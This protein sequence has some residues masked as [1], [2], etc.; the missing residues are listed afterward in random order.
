MFTTEP[1]ATGHDEPGHRERAAYGGSDGSGPAGLIDPALLVSAV[2][3]ARWLIV[4][5]GLLGAGIAAAYA[6]S[7]PKIY[8]STTQILLDPRDIKVIQN[9]ITPNGLPS[10]AT[11]A[12]VESQ[13]A[14][15]YSNEILSRAVAAEGLTTDPEYVGGSA[16]GMGAIIASINRA[17][18]G[19]A[20]TEAPD[21][22]RRE[23]RVIEA[24][25]RNLSVTRD[26]NSFI[27]NL[28]VKS[29]V[30]DRAARLSTTIARLFIDNL[31]VVQ[32][33]TARR[34]S[35]SLSS[36]LSELRSRV[37]SAERAV[38][39]YKAE[40]ALIGVGG[41]LVD[42]DYIIRMNDQLARAR[43][44]ITAL[45]VRAG[46]MQNASVEDVVQGTLPEELTSEAL[47]RLRTT[48]SQLAQESA[49]L[50]ARLGPRHP[51]RI[52][53]DEALSSAR[54][55]IEAELRRI[56]SA[57]QTELARA[58]LTEQQLSSQT[59]ELK[60]KQVTTSGSFVRLR[61]LEREVDASRAVYEAYLLR[62]RETG[63]Q[64]SI[65]TANVRIV[66]EAVPALDPVSLSR[67]VVIAAGG[68][69]GGVLAAA[70]AVVVA[71]GRIMFAPPASSGPR[72][73]FAADGRDAAPPEHHPRHADAPA[74]RDL[75]FAAPG[76][77]ASSAAFFQEV[78]RAEN[79]PAAA[80]ASVP[81]SDAAQPDEDDRAPVAEPAAEAR[82]ETEATGPVGEAPAPA[83]APQPAAAAR[84]EAE[85]QP[86]EAASLAPEFAEIRSEIEAVRHQLSLLRA[87]RARGRT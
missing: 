51:Q 60:A 2:W 45:R 54:S 10:E 68:I 30:P 23:L 8:A 72:S 56:V 49:V 46:S 65:N 24:L 39:T 70:L 32:A 38:E 29:Q 9:E 6:Y 43:A 84:R 47:T 71:I 83:P 13:L 26:P 87:R 7:M 16:L 4:L 31:G 3:R 12:L 55:A 48:Y 5:C 75:G 20:Q 21:P 14:V 34:A 11:L 17:V 36:R 62:A 41:R 66:S 52:A 81:V 73:P 19:E 74:R 78:E 25:R 28:T 33:D 63:E 59:D 61:E 27:I 86:G 40:N 37:V 18:F 76:M 64:E 57:A 22:R 15:I 79:R 82:A 80:F 53:S 85:A 50:R 42:D 44:D 69:V 35:E 77:A 58:E 67:K 1:T